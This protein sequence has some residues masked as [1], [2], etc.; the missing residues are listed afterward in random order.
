MCWWASSGGGGS[1]EIDHRVG[2]AASLMLRVD[3]W[4][5]D[6]KAMMVMRI[7]VMRGRRMTYPLYMYTQSQTITGPKQKNKWDQDRSPITGNNHSK[8][9]EEAGMS[10]SRRYTWR[11]QPQRH[12]LRHLTIINMFFFKTYTVWI[13]CTIWSEI[14]IRKG[15]NASTN[16]DCSTLQTSRPNHPTTYTYTTHTHKQQSVHACMHAC[17]HSFNPPYSLYHSFTRT[18]QASPLPFITIIHPSIINHALHGPLSMAFVHARMTL[19][20]LA[21]NGMH[22]H[23]YRLPTTTLQKDI[24]TCMHA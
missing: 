11:A 9:I 12:A 23:A 14:A 6:L 24:H 10:Q 17:I 22:L 19:P 16:D 5:T 8:S 3:S 15:S 21:H 4:M 1:G 20:W 2:T 13:N 18:N 7:C